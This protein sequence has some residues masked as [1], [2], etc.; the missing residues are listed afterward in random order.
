MKECDHVD[1]EG[2]STITF[3]KRNKITTTGK[4]AVKGVCRKCGKTV[5]VDFEEYKYLVKEGQ[6]W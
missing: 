4:L 6:R 5:L 1:N 3:P 2:R